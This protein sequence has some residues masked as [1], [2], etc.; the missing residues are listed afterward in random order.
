MYFLNVVKYI[1]PYIGVAPVYKTASFYKILISAAFQ[2]PNLH[3]QA[4]SFHA[5]LFA[6]S[7][8]LKLLLKLFSRFLDEA[9]TKYIVLSINFNKYT[10]FPQDKLWLSVDFLEGQEGL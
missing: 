3:I 5:K 6:W 7:Q 1:F 9:W 10:A 2:L 4:D 8:I